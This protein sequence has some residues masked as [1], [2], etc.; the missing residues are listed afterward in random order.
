MIDTVANAFVATVVQ[1]GAVASPLR[2][3]PTP[4]PESPPVQPDGASVDTIVTGLYAAVSHGPEYEPNWERLRR[5]FLPG[6]HVLPPKRPDQEDFA[7]LDVDAFEER[8]RKYIAGRRERNEQLGFTEREIGR[9]Q[10]R[11]GDVCQVF[12]AYETV[13]APRDPA[14]FARGVHSIQLVY[15][16]RRWWIASLAWDNEGA[17]KSNPIPP[18]LSRNEKLA[19]LSR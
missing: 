7:V 3:T 16:G 13:R 2:K 11:F 8:I 10:G 5:L 18:D 15:D 6:A 17:D 14:P 9:R 19:P 12:S 4:T 1:S